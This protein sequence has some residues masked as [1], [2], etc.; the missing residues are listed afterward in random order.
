M[1]EVI[2]MENEGSDT[3][4]KNTE[5]IIDEIQ[6]IVLIE[7]SKV[8][9]DSIADNE[10]HQCDTTL[11]DHDVST[12]EDENENDLHNIRSETFYKDAQQYWKAIPPTV[13]GM[14]GGFSS[15]N[16]T[17]IRGSQDF[18]KEVFKMKPSPNKSIALDCGAG[19]FLFL[20]MTEFVPF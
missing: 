13:D 11:D 10:I 14:L 1:N 4:P 12:S 3:R 5:K 9:E 2:D 17:D 16:F 20:F 19:M 15:I 6:N 7:K 18:L 8:S